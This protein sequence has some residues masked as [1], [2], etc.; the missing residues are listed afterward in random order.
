MWEKFKKLKL[1]FSFTKSDVNEY[2]DRRGL[3][4]A[5]K[6][7]PSWSFG[8]LILRFYFPSVFGRCSKRSV[9]SV[10]FCGA[11]EGSIW[12]LCFLVRKKRCTI[13]NVEF[14]SNNFF[15]SKA[16]SP[17]FQTFFFFPSFLV[18]KKV[19]QEFKISETFE[20]YISEISL[21]N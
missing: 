6:A 8:W 19:S 21:I 7:A 14:P 13:Y 9:K 10:F 11:G 16:Q 1:D 4:R 17:K 2:I 3:R 15:Q 20:N 18:K 12:V 5:A